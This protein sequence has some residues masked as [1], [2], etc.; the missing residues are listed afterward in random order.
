MTL[1]V[2]GELV[3]AVRSAA[4]A[5]GRLTPSELSE[6]AARDIARGRHCVGPARGEVQGINEAGELLVDTGS[7]VRAFRDGSLTF[8]GAPA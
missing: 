2:L 7:E 6:F 4:G 8:A 1:A 3:P 5:R